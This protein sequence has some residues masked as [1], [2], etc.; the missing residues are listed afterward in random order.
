MYT[1]HGNK[2]AIRVE[3]EDVELAVL[4][5][6]PGVVE[7]GSPGSVAFRAPVARSD[8]M[9]ASHTGWFGSLFDEFR[10]AI[11]R[12]EYV[13]KDAMEA[14]LCIELIERAYR[15]AAEGSRLVDL[16]DGSIDRPARLRVPRP[17]LGPGR[18][19]EDLA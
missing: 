12:S 17:L 13:G 1:L 7:P 6:G 3:D 5:A 18:E 9:D 8:W 4:E 15:S 14:C 19:A 11:A 10:G 16:L 2:G